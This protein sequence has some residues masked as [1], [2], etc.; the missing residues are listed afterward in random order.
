MQEQTGSYGQVAACLRR[1]LDL[2]AVYH[3]QVQ[4]LQQL[5]QHSD[6][7]FLFA[8]LGCCGCESDASIHR[9]D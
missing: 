6:S 3:W 1:W 8:S 7:C 2:L 9:N 5:Q 4:R